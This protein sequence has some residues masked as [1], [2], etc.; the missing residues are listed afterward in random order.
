MAIA[1]HFQRKLLTA[2]VALCVTAQ[3]EGSETAQEF[4]C[5]TRDD[6]R[7]LFKVSGHMLYRC[8]Q[9]GSNCDKQEITSTRTRDNE[10]N[11]IAVLTSDDRQTTLMTDH[12][13][14][15]VRSN[16]LGEYRTDNWHV[17]VVGWKTDNPDWAPRGNEIFDSDNDTLVCHR[18]AWK[19]T[20]KHSPD[21]RGD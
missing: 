15:T 9:K 21:Y 14:P 8:D 3:V 7:V 4:K 20:G 10:G 17:M 18:N 6:T 11:P 1:H 2:L 5:I 16:K 13:F 19:L 12:Y